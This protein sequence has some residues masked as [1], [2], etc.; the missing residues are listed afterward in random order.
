MNSTP[1]ERKNVLNCTDEL[2]DL[3]D[4]GI[5]YERFEIIE[6]GLSYCLF[7]YS[8]SN[9]YQYNC[10]PS[11]N[12]NLIIHFYQF[13]SSR[14]ILFEIGDDILENES[15]DCRAI[16]MTNSRIKQK[17][18]LGAGTQVRGLTVLVDEKWLDK[19]VNNANAKNYAQLKKNSFLIDVIS[20]KFQK[21]LNDIFTNHKEA[22]LPTLFITSRVL[23]LLE[24]FLEK[25]LKRDVIE[26]MLSISS[27][28]FESILKIEGLLLENYSEVFPKIEKL[29]RIALMSES[30][31]KK[32][33]KRAFGMGLYKYYQ[34]NRM[35]KAKQLLSTGEYSVTQVGTILGYHNLSN[36]SSSF[37]K[38][39]NKL[40][41]DF[42]QVG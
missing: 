4:H 28:D 41:R 30:K 15:K 11:A 27:K 18:S 35:H 40:P 21:I 25:I 36:F 13:T 24:G 29:A 42:Q 33:Y 23:R 16:V 39:F 14:K 31:L 9:D 37:K 22:Q 20:A 8:L 10:E 1:Q 6:P 7:D 26:P 12:F 5:G 2:P 3:S 38:E 34:K 19:R 17:L 32:I